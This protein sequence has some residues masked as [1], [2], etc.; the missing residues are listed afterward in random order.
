MRTH[1]FCIA[2]FISLS[3]IASAQKSIL[4]E[5]GQVIF[6]GYIGDHYDIV[7]ILKK[8]TGNKFEG[9]YIYKKQTTFISLSG[10]LKDN[11]LFLS[12]KDP[13]GKETGKFTI[14]LNLAVYPTMR[15]NWTK[16]NGTGKL[17]LYLKRV[18]FPVA[19][20]AF[21]KVKSTKVGNDTLVVA[22]GLPAPILS[23]VNALLHV[24]RNGEMQ[25]MK[26]VVEYNLNG[27]LTVFYNESGSGG[28]AS[29]Q[30]VCINTGE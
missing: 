1:L 8:T 16:P 15:G 17:D 20:Y 29:S 2:F 4:D 14:D 3:Q 22:S 26:N 30:I 9:R 7:M 25:S 12:E 6:D 28:F 19:S 5:P 21:V 23:K 18:P 13:K 27:I 10:E 24:T 11:K